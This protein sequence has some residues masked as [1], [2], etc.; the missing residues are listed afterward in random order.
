MPTLSPAS[1]ERLP[2]A[3]LGVPFDNVTSAETLALITGMIA[4]GQPHYAALVNVDFLMQAQRDVELRRILF[5]AHLVLAAGKPILS[6]AKFLGNQLPQCITAAEL[7]PQLL[8]LAEQKNWRVFFLGGTDSSI[9]TVAEKV[10]AKFPGLQIVGTH[11]P[12]LQP[13]LEMDHP[14]IKR[15]IREVKPDLLFV[16][17]GCPKQEKWIN[18]NFRSL[19]VPFTIGVGAALEHFAGAK[20]TVQ[21]PKATSIKNFFSF[22]LAVFQQGRQLRG[23][24]K[25]SSSPNEANVIPDPYGNLVIRAPARLG[26][27]EVEICRAE[28]LRAVESSHVMFDLSD[29]TFADSTGIGV[30][31]R[32]RKRARELNQQFF[33]VALRP[34]IEAALRQ[35]KLDEFFSVQNSLAGARI[36]MES[37]SSSPTVSSGVKEKNLQ[38]RWTGEVTAL[39]AVELGVQT[40]SE[41]SQATPGMSVVVDLS[42]VTFVDSTGIGL[43]LRFKKNL[44][45]QDVALQFANPVTS[46]RNVLRQTKLEEYLLGAEK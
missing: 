27:A 22:K 3:I 46:V 4:S 13:L 38:I 6:A 45:H 1:T 25:N 28:W 36:I 7:L 8:A 15:K 39:N 43:M 20:E 37:I 5:D 44:K 35:M 33:L 9:A 17:F 19:N 12:I 2:L 11:A 42:R 30:L 23:R 41:L 29:T 31:I 34:P 26:A 16:A 18:M 24:K 21:N 10:R 32:L 14:A 40:E